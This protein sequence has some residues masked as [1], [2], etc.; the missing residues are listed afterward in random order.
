[1]PPKKTAPEN[2]KFEKLI[3]RTSKKRFL[4]YIK[5]ELL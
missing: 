5:A 1:M 4:E 2:N 3:F